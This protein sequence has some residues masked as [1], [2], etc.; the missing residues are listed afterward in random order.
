VPWA[1]DIARTGWY[2]FAANADGILKIANHGVGRRVHPGEPRVVDP[3]QEGRFRK[4][5]GHTFPD[6]V[7]APVVGSR[8]CLYSDTWDGNFWIDHDPD[9]PGLVVASGGSGHGFKFAPL[10]GPLIADVVEGK[11]NPYAGRFAWRSRG[12]LTTEAARSVG[13]GSE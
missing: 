13:E 5:L 11:P 12:E 9:R 10:L 4:F 6:L 2:G 1:A 8:L 7:D 3:H